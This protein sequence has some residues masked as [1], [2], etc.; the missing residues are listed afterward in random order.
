MY[1]EKREDNFKKCLI[2]PR[3]QQKQ[4]RLVAIVVSTGS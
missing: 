4:Q 3:K 2:L 1:G